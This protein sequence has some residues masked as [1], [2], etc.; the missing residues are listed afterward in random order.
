MRRLSIIDVAGGHQ[1]IDNEDH[2]VT[3]V[4]NG[5]IY[6]YKALRDDLQGQGHFFR[7]RTDT[8][9]I[10]HAYEEHD[11]ECVN[12]FN[13]IFAF[14]L[15]DGAKRRLLLARDRMGVKPLYYTLGHNGLAFA[16]EIKALL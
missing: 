1:P 9:T 11:A 2:S 15:W 8:E 14:A 10:V 12:H 4:F 13:G 6:N 16:S 5:E 7:T 3:V